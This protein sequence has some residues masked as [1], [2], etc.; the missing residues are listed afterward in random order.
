MKVYRGTARATTRRVWFSN[1]PAELWG[2]GAWV[3]FKSLRSWVRHPILTFGWWRV[4]RK[5]I[6]LNDVVPWDDPN[7]DVAGD[8]TK[9]RF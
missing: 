2:M 8:L 1:A 5:M 7:H 9:K 4:C 3:D 6:P